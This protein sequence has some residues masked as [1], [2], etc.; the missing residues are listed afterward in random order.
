[1]LGFILTRQDQ[2]NMIDKFVV[3]LRCHPGSS[4]FLWSV[5]ATIAVALFSWE[6]SSPGCSS[7]CSGSRSCRT[8][9]AGNQS[10]TRIK[11]H[12]HL[13]LSFATL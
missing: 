13:K 4:C 8:V 10:L 3:Q 11:V 12:E 1:M 9:V 5:S 7:R 6:G 2:Q